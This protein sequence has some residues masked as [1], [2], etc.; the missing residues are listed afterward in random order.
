MSN[1]FTT[2]LKPFTNLNELPRQRHYH[3]DIN[4]KQEKDKNGMQ[5]V[6]F[7]PSDGP[8]I[9]ENTIEEY[10]Q[11]ANMIDYSIDEML[12]TLNKYN[13]RAPNFKKEDGKDAIMFFGDSFTFGV[14]VRDE[15]VYP[16]LVCNHLNKINW[17]LGCGGIDNKIML[18]IL[19]HFIGMGYIPSMVVVNWTTA[20]RKLL[21]MNDSFSKNAI[22]GRNQASNMFDLKFDGNTVHEH[23]KVWSPDWVLKDADSLR[24][25]LPAKAWTMSHE[26]EMYIDFYNT[27]NSFHKTCGLND[28]PLIEMFNHEDVA[29][30]SY[31]MDGG[32]PT[33]DMNV[34]ANKFVAHHPQYMIQEFGS[35]ENAYKLHEK[36]ASEG[37]DWGRDNLHW[38][39]KRQKWCYDKTITLI[40]QAN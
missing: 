31:I 30:F 20:H 38:G 33:T 11:T 3:P 21:M 32:T 10:E 23:Y 12:Y 34:W 24:N 35:V 19:E 36:P 39:P 40:N 17:N 29:Y 18:Y 28:I 6:Q 13:W 2:S 9:G 16:Q 5:K 22:P 15:E 37:G 8:I 7:I 27:R 4:G 25:S 26:N 14:G 1:I